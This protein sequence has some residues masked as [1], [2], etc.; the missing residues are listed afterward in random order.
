[1]EKWGNLQYQPNLPLGESRTYV[2][3]GEAHIALSLKA[4]K[5]G[6]VLLKNQAN[7][8][9][10]ARGT[11]VALFGKGSFDYVK[12]GGGSGQVYTAYSRNLHEGLKLQNDKVQI[13]EKLS[14][15]YKQAVEAQYE[16]GL[17][18]GMTEE[19]QIPEELLREAA[20]YTDT[21]IVAISRFSGE[22]W[23]RASGKLA[24]KEGTDSTTPKS[25]EKEKNARERNTAE[26][27]TE[28][29]NPLLREKKMMSLSTDLFERGDFYLSLR[30]QALVEAVTK[31]FTHVIIVMNVGGMVDT[32]W[33]KE[34]PCI[35]AVLMAWQAGIEGGMAMAQLLVG[36]ANPCGKLSDTFAASLEDY[37]STW[38]FHESEDY[39]DYTDDIYVGYR[40][41]ETIPGASQKVNYPFGFGLSYTD[42]QITCARV[43][44]TPTGFSFQV[45]VVNTGDIPGKE[46]VQIYVKAPQG[47]LGKPEKEL[48]AFG[49]TRLL[50]AGEAQILTLFVSRA[51]L[52]S[53]DDLGKVQRSAYILEE[54]I[55]RFFVG[56][57]VRDGS[58]TDYVY[59]LKHPLIVE[60]LTQKLAPAQLKKR[61]CADGSWEELPLK[62]PHDPDAS[63]IGKIPFAEMEEYTP[64]VREQKGVPLN[65]N[66]WDSSHPLLEVAEGKLSMEAFIDQLSDEDL[67]CLLGGQPNTGVANTF[68]FGNLPQW[69]VPNIMT[70][71]GPAGLRIHPKCG[72]S[73]TAW[74]CATLL[75]CTWNPKLA[76]QVG[77][78]GAREVKENHI[79][80]WLTPGINI[81]RSPLC[82]RN[83]EYYSEDPLLTGKMAGA[84]VHGI[85]SEHIAA[86]VKHFAFNNKETN[87]RNSDSRVSERAAREI[88]LK[89]FEII[90]KEQNPWT[91]MSSYNMINGHRCSE[92]RE[93]LT[94]I[95]R[96]EWGF[97]GMVTTDWWNWGEHYKETKAGNDVKMGC[98]YPKRLLLAKEQMLLTREEMEVCGK[99]IL[100]LIL[101]MD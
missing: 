91:I 37:P 48:K 73:T 38:N 95:L 50:Q 20:A 89:A 14:H 96:G 16:E 78:A 62:V 92:C 24:D 55:Y 88:Y 67:A 98:G 57:S 47:K 18:P 6:M 11:K 35:Q 71:D 5:E 46:V 52:A 33:F 49:K 82:G 72:V 31:N 86:S 83:F 100:E 81:H 17:P 42:F 87:R 4:A 97:Q 90:V 85:Q 22:G 80:V 32:S 2:T 64:G 28:A 40:Y 74:P 21:A 66:L 51:S 68:G 79:G 7:I 8:L 27:N 69:G 77:I 12:G 29:E 58:W 41:F 54:G 44:E 45:Q 101:R 56:N 15:F 25:T 26:G 9:P 53:Y 93:L 61:L 99:R 75:A 76:E 1:M 70:A 3:G 23:D 30:E 39:V 84:M 10:L 59:E 34:N 19:P 43:T 94:D 13:F 65:P 60:Q 36:E 63:G